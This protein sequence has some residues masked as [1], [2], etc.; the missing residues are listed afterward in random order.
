[1]VSFWGIGHLYIL[2]RLNYAGKS[3]TSNGTEKYIFLKIIFRA[4]FS[5]RLRKLSMYGFQVRVKSCSLQPWPCKYSLSRPFFLHPCLSGN[6]GVFSESLLFSEYHAMEISWC[7]DGA[8]DGDND[9]DCLSVRDEAD[10]CLRRSAGIYTG[11]RAEVHVYMAIHL[12]VYRRC[13]D[14]YGFLR[15]TFH[16]GTLTGIYQHTALMGT[17]KPYHEFIS[18]AFD[19]A[20]SPL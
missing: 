7:V 17:P 1:M 3:Q 13:A 14:Y 16:V 15:F 10:V 19:Y 2:L 5:E 20:P 4:F 8:L 12:Y 11:K 18:V 9:S 6:Q